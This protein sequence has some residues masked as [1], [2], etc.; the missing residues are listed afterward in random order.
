L[1]W[2]YCNPLL[3]NFNGNYG[4]TR[5]YTCVDRVSSVTTLKQDEEDS[6]DNWNEVQRQTVEGRE[7][8]K[9]RF[10]FKIPET[11]FMRKNA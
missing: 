6:S 9:M 4:H 7:V 5:T 11:W 8:S 1:S 2:K 10:G 3:G